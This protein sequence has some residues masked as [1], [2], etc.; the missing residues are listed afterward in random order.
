MGN[1]LDIVAK[2]RIDF[3]SNAQAANYVIFSSV[4]R[5]RRFHIVYKS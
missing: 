2:L 1:A 3:R 4:V 5:I